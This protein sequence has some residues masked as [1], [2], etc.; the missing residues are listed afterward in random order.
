MTVYLVGAG[1]GDPGMLTLRGMHLLRRADVVIHDRLVSQEILVHIP[2]RAKT[3]SLARVPPERRTLVVTDLFLEHRDVTTL[4]RL[5]N[6]D[7]FIFGRGGE[8]AQFLQQHGI[9]FEY[10]PGVSSLYSVLGCAGIPLTFR[11]R[12]SSFTVLTWHGSS[13][14]ETL[15]AGGRPAPLVILMGASGCRSVSER[16][17]ALGYEKDTP[18]AAVSWGSLPRQ[19]VRRS[20]LEGLSTAE[21]EA[22][23]V[24]LIGGTADV[25]TGVRTPAPLQRVK[26]GIARH[27]THISED[28]A[29]LASLGADPVP[30]PLIDIVE[31]PPPPLPG[32]DGFDALVL[33]SRE[34]ARIA[35]RL[36]PEGER[37]PPVYV[38]G[39]GTAGSVHRYFGIHPHIPDR[40]TSGGLAALLL[41]DLPK[42]AKALALR[43]AQASGELG[44]LL[45][46][47][48]RE[49]V[50]VP[51]YDVVPRMDEDVRRGIARS[52]TVF[53]YSRSASM[54]LAGVREMLAGKTVVAIG[55]RA[56]SPLVALQGFTLLTAEHA[57]LHGMVAVMLR[58]MWCRHVL[59]EDLAGS[60]SRPFHSAN[61]SYG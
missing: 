34:G 12:N 24:L 9:P 28:L 29:A 37:L 38:I 20:S 47:R 39:P 10:V 61:T 19:M 58:H 25:D 33:T 48:G 60:Q 15:L 18:C 30:I 3:I 1:P 59:P 31:R 8:E 45:A 21:I 7:P 40:W 35:A 36:L 11:G 26:I 23:A 32:L 4:V 17:I 41:R 44:M 49:L 50:P 5:K 27:R 16:L 55:E 6:G 46:E 42:G 22:P 14:L 52:E 56:A 2:P 53:T 54:V 43:S 13:D 57:S 51:I